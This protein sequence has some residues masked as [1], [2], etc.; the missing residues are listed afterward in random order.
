MCKMLCYLLFTY[1]L[2]SLFIVSGTLAQD[3][4]LVNTVSI[5]GKLLMLDDMTP[6]VNVPVQTIRDGKVIATT[7]SDDSGKYQFINLKPGWYQV[8]CQ[9]PGEFLY[10]GED[11]AE[12]H[13]DG[14]LVKVEPG[15]TVSKIDFRFAPFKKG[16]WRNFTTLDGLPY[17]VVRDIY[18]DPD[19][20]L[21]VATGWHGNLGSVSRY[22]GEKFLDINLQNEAKFGN[23]WT[24]YRDINGVFWFGTADFPGKGIF[25]YDGKK[26]L[27]LD[28]RDGLLSNW[29]KDI[30][31]DQNGIMWFGTARGVSRY[32]G[33]KFVNFTTRDGLAGG[34]VRAVYGDPDGIMWFGTGG[35]VSVYNGREFVNFTTKDGLPS[36]SVTEI[37]RDSDGIMWFGTGND[38][39][40]GGGGGISRYDG[41]KFYNLTTTDGLASNCVLAIH[42]DS[43]GVM[44]FGTDNGVSRYDGKTFVNFTTED[45]LAHNVVF[46]IYADKDGAKWFGTGGGLSRFDEKRLYNLTTRDGLVNNDVW[47]FHRVSD[48]DI[49]I[50]TMNGASRFDGRMFTN[51]TTK[52]GLASDS[53]RAIYESSDG[54]LWFGGWSG[55]SRYDGKEFTSFTREDGLA[56]TDVFNIYSDKNGILWFGATGISRYDGREFA[57]FT[58]ADGLGRGGVVPICQTPDGIFWFGTDGGVSRYDGKKFN[59]FTIEDGLSNN[60]VNAIHLAPDGKLWFGTAG[61]LS[62]YDG[63]KFANLTTKDGLVHN[64]IRAIYRDS[65]GLLWFG[66]EGGG[67]CMYDG[68]AW[69]SLDTRDG[70]AGNEV[71]IIDEESDGYLWFGTNGGI[72]CYR[73]NRVSPEVRIVSVITDQIYEDL[74]AIP[75]FSV[76]TRITI[77]YKAIDFTTIPEKRQYRFRVKG[78]DIDWRKPTKAIEYDWI[79][80]K[81]GFYSFEVQ[82]IDQDLNYSETASL[83][84]G[85]VTPFYR[86]TG[87][88]LLVTLAGAVLLLT[89]IVSLTAYTKRRKQIHTYQQLAVKELQDAR[90]MQ[91]SLLPD[92]FPEIEGMEVSGRSIPANTVGGDF[93]DYLTLP[94]GRI[95]ICIGDVSGKGL[96]AAMNAVLAS[97]M[98]YEVIKTEASSGNILSELNT[99]LYPR[100]GKQ[101]FTAFAF[102]ILDGDSGKIQWS[103]GAQPIPLVKK[104]DRASEAE[105]E[106]ELP[107]G[108]TP[109]VVYSDWE[110]KLESGD[111]AIFY[112]DGIIEAE[113]EDKEMYGIERLVRSVDGMNPALSAEDIINAIFRDVA[114]FMDNESQYDDMTVVVLKKV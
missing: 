6:H 114:D 31:G 14:D 38:W 4:S 55:L 91:M 22:D 16:T 41:E 57:K 71:R 108:M 70:L 112:T 9:V 82:A 83:E 35:G 29:V 99:G 24:L 79:P 18:R 34:N 86:T 77:G 36:N 19:G 27:N 96:R 107:L 78:V 89:S 37:Y 21:W 103:S 93:F 94:D 110:L 51:L 42:Q 30:Y 97:G 13:E 1:L 88:I 43:D 44:W 49:W 101:M 50:G 85:V 40:G 5:E 52:D 2:L 3:S 80:K 90:E 10:Y 53:I 75:K 95:G 58:A 68:M 25:C 62:I 61:G 87:F 105:G 59:N 7:L 74:S 66:T 64:S 73:R 20:I 109:D 46:A 65:E 17:S 92:A 104:D 72:T 102:A 111:V 47:T 33:K 28:E 76:G 11:K 100:M 32:D 48:K 67:V 12:N 23:I 39:F 84:L 63:K 15:K 113:N 26:L 98:L 56:N 45:G 81:P 54:T 8:R 69:A 60:D 106:G